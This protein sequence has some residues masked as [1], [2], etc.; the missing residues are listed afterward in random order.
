MGNKDKPRYDK[1]TGEEVEPINS[2]L[3]TDLNVE[4]DK[5]VICE[6]KTEYT[7][8]VHIDFRNHYV[9][10]CGQLC[11]SCWDNTYD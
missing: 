9:E 1:I 3:T 6:V 5:C 4:L 10:G 11:K 7:K 2:Y 8:D